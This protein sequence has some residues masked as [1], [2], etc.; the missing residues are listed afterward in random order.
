MLPTRNAATI[1]ITNHNAY[2]IAD[3]SAETLMAAPLSLLLLESVSHGRPTPCSGAVT[4]CTARR[5]WWAA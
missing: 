2:A 1:S 5:V 4:P 3:A